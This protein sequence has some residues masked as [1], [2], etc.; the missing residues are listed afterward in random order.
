MDA[1]TSDRWCGHLCPP[2][3][4]CVLGVVAI[5]RIVELAYAKRLTM[6]ASERGEA[7]KREP[8]FVVMVALHASVFALVP[9]E[10]Y[11]LDRPFRPWL[12]TVSCAALAILFVMRVWTLKTLG[13]RWNVRI[14]KP[15]AIVVDGPYKWVRHP[16]YAIVI[17]ELIVIPLLQGAWITCVVLT[18]LNAFVLSRRI[19]PEE[20]VLFE[21]PGYREQMGTKPRFIPW[22]R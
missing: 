20:R 10:V 3:L 11:F 18:A 12:F 17:A 7:A 5:A 2:W 9:L 8:I 4:L 14:V 15:D 16:N 19:P 21:L 13:N 22:G 6:R 1:V